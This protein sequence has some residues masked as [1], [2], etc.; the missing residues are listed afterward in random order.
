[1]HKLLAFVNNCPTCI[2]VFLAF[3][4]LALISFLSL[5]TSE[6]LFKLSPDIPGFDK[7]VHFFMY[8]SLGV[9]LRWVFWNHSFDKV[10]ST[11]VLGGVFAYGLAMEI[12]QALF[13]GGIREFG[14]A[15]AWANIAGA[16]V[17]WILAGWFLSVVGSRWTVVGGR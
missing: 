11:W 15:D 6:D 12:M 16:V 3:S 5:S 8:G 10:K 4:Y 13:T 1:M 9:L 2:R 14:W 7:I 17:F